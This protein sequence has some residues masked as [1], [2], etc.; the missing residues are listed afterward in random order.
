MLTDYTAQALFI[1]RYPLQTSCGDT[2]LL[3]IFF[4]ILGMNCNY[5]FCTHKYICCIVPFIILFTQAK[6]Q[7]QPG[8]KLGGDVKIINQSKYILSSAGSIEKAYT[9]VYNGH[10]YDV[11][12]NPDKNIKAIFINDRTFMTADSIKIGMPY[13][14]I[15]H[16]LLN[17]QSHVY[18]GWA[19]FYDSKSG[20]KI[21]FDFNSAVADTSRVQF[22]FK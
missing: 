17:K 16:L 7:L 18:P 11:T 19:H 10:T 12:L 4:L 6:A 2:C 14:Q 20:W 3:S 22:I 21:A 15:E 8:Q 5:I 13:S 1:D 9:V